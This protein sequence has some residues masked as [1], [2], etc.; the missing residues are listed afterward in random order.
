[1]RTT[2]HLV[3][4]RDALALV[5]VMRDVSVRGFRNTP[6]AKA[7]AG[8]DTDAVLARSRAI[9]ADAPRTPA[10]LG[11]ALAIDWPDRDPP[12]LA[13]LSRYHLALVQVPPR[14]LWRQAGRTTNTTVE[15]W[16]GSP[17]GAGATVD[18]V[19]LRYLAAF[20]PATVGDIRVWSWLTGLREVVDRLRPRL[21]TF[22]DERGR[23]LLDVE[24]GLLVDPDT[25]A[26]VRFLPQ[27]DN[28]FLSHEDRSRIEGALSWGL[29]FGGKGVILID[30]GINGAWRVRRERKV[31]TLTVELGRALRPTERRD[32]DD[33]AERLAMFLDPDGR[34]E[35]V[36]VPAA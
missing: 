22:R 13:Y 28:V 24:D 36:V 30:G 25:P 15:S 14:G 12:S 7:L 35:T 31:A 34:R 18:E 19:V 20:G 23:E 17:L 3:T 26:P 4:A 21:R 2:L 8:V 10:Q 6:F 1:M 5:P 29:G 33:E 11:T 9:L 27:Y 32:L 16:L